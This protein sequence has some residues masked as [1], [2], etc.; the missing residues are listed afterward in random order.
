MLQDDTSLAEEAR[1]ELQQCDEQLRKLEVNS[2]IF[3]Y[4]CTVRMCG[5]A[6]VVREMIPR[7]ES[8]EHSAVLE[9][10]AGIYVFID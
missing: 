3:C 2:C 10:R 4:V 1:Q 5:Q 9:V 7:D 8:D 6:A